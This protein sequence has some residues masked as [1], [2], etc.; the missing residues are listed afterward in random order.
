MGNT[1]SMKAPREHKHGD[2][3]CT[4]KHGRRRR[5]QSTAKH[6]GHKRSGHKRSGHK[7]HGTKRH[8]T[9]RHGKKHRVYSGSSLMVPISPKKKNHKRYYGGV[10]L[11]PSGGSAPTYP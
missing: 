3:T 4:M 10:M 8:G 6:S 1:T 7:R 9:K 2:V 5:Q 11:P